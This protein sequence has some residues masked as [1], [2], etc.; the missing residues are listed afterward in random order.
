MSNLV[1]RYQTLKEINNLLS[2]R[3]LNTLEELF[4]DPNHLEDLIEH[5][6]VIRHMLG[7]PHSIWFSLVFG[8]HLPICNRSNDNL[9]RKKLGYLFS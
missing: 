7:E 4:S 5:F 8:E 2:Y 6:Y 9:T 3:C 1:N